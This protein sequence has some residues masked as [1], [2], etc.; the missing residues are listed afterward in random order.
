[1]KGKS[2]NNASY[3]RGQAFGQQAFSGTAFKENFYF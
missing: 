3:T 1:M 2:I